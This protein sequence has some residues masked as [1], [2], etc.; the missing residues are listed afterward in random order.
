MNVDE[1]RDRVSLQSANAF[2]QSPIYNCN[3]RDSC[4]SNENRNQK[5]NCV[6]VNMHALNLL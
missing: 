2:A 4:Q 6:H 1:M 5:L 3:E